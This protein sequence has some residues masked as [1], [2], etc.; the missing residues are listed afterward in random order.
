MKIYMDPIAY[1]NR[2]KRRIE[3]QVRPC[4]SIVGR[5]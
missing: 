2:L 1:Y 5:V 3:E 4:Y